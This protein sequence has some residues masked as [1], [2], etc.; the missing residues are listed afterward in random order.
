M[1]A[2]EAV[3]MGMESCEIRENISLQDAAF[4]YQAYIGQRTGELIM[5]NEEVDPKAEAKRLV[6]ML[7][8]GVGKG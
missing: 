5:K 3:E 1:Q 7:W 6:A 4:A 2:A 8:Y